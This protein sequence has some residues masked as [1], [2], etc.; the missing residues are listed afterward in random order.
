MAS[1]E[2]MADKLYLQPLVPRPEGEK[3]YAE[4]C[5]LRFDAGAVIQVLLDP[6]PSFYGHKEAT[7]AAFLSWVLA[8]D[9]EGF[10]DEFIALAVKRLLAKAEDRAAKLELSSPLHTD[11]TARYLIA[12]PQFIDEIYS[13]TSPLLPE[14]GSPL[15]TE[16]IFDLDRGPIY[17][18]NKMMAF[19]HHIADDPNKGKPSVN[20]AIEMV[21][22]IRE[23][24]ISSRSAIYTQW[25]K[26]KD[27]IALIYAASSI[28]RGKG[29][30]IDDL[31]AG[32]IDY[33]KYI[34]HFPEWIGRA[35]YVCEHILR[36]MPDDQLYARNVKPLGQVAAVGFSHPTFAPNEL[37]ALQF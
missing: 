12:G 25:A 23:H 16:K 9:E 28:R 18:L 17:T 34:K 13:C 30:L 36:Q 26:C 19:C 4:M 37:E 33:S 2:A 21:G 27:N 14:Y 15:V 24:G 20:R 8:P 31:V 3:P 7:F 32:E 29:W 35:R 1:I 5:V 11:L 6:D 10:R 22:N